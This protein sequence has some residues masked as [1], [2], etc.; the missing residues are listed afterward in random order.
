[1]APLFVG[2]CI[3]T[4]MGCSPDIASYD[5]LANESG[6]EREARSRYGDLFTAVE[7]L[8]RAASTADD[9]PIDSVLVKRASRE[10]DRVVEVIQDFPGTVAS[11]VAFDAVSYAA[12]GLAVSPNLGHAQIEAF[13]E[14]GLLVPLFVTGFKSVTEGTRNDSVHLQILKALQRGIG[15]APTEQMLTDCMPILSVV[16]SEE[17]MEFCNADTLVFKKIHDL[18]IYARSLQEVDPPLWLLS[19]QWLLGLQFGEEVPIF[20]ILVPHFVEGVPYLAF[21]DFRPGDVY[22]EVYDD[23]VPDDRTLWDS[24]LVRADAVLGGLA[25]DTAFAGRVKQSE[26]PDGEA[27]Y[28]FD[29]YLVQTTADSVK[30]EIYLTFYRQRNQQGDFEYTGKDSI[31]VV[32]DEPHIGQFD[33]QVTELAADR[34]IGASLVGGRRYARQDLTGTA[35]LMQIGEH[36]LA[37]PQAYLEQLRETLGT[38]EISVSVEPAPVAGP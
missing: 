35:Y 19:G 14:N 22:A 5:D 13:W 23:P 20:I 28:F 18:L 31:T 7:R 9:A 12:A 6:V 37:I 17:I 11:R 10:V 8:D 32:F 4:A 25:F 15:P 30:R 27:H 16:P 36:D 29:D 33:G 34:H 24:W 3:I 21:R 26:L 1:M 2:L 38:P